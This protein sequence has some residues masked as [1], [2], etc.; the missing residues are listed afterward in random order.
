MGSSRGALK[1]GASL[2][3]SYICQHHTSSSW[4]AS[5]KNLPSDMLAGAKWHIFKDIHCSIVRTT[6]PSKRPRWFNEQ[7]CN[8]KGHRYTENKYR[9]GRSLYQQVHNDKYAKLFKRRQRW[10]EWITK[11][12]PTICCLQDTHFRSKYA[13]SWK[14]NDRKTYSTLTVTKDSWIGYINIRQNRLQ[15]KK[16]LQG[17]KKDLIIMKKSQ[18]IQKI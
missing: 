6:C 12:D 16:S 17:T 15:D 8:K 11:H 4:S 14:W 3:F 7:H 10:T 5:Y 2:L 1:K 9:N 18:F 13:N